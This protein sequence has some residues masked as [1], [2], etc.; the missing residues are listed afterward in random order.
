MKRILSNTA[1][2]LVELI[3]ATLLVVVIFFGIEAVNTVLR[4]SNE[5]YGQRYFVKAD[6]Q[7]T[8]NHMLN[9]ASTAVG[10]ANCNDEAILVGSGMTL[11]SCT[12]GGGSN[13]SAN[14]ICMH[15]QNSTGSGD[16]WLCY[17]WSGSAGVSPNMPQ[18]YSIYSCTESYPPAAVTNPGSVA[19]PRGAT[20]CNTAGGATFLG[21][22]VV[23]PSAS[24]VPTASPL[25][26]SVT[27]TN[28][29]NN[30]ASA[31][32][33]DNPEVQLSGSVAPMQ[34]SS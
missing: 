10:S 24:F 34:A 15:E 23:A 20:D 27:I 31:D 17:S 22:S 12:S 3:F 4:N 30:A 26:F 6:T 16:Y 9:N 14:T 7:A 2:S 32:P 19:D 28:R 25:Q 8:L 1:V 5:D 18:P 29:L 33:A 13:V 11:N 21:T